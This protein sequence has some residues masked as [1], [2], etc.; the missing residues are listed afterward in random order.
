MEEEATIDDPSVGEGWQKEGRREG[1]LKTGFRSASLCAQFNE[2]RSLQL[3]TTA[4][5]MMGANLE[6]S[7]G[8]KSREKQSS[9]DMATDEIIIEGRRE[10]YSLRAAQH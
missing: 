9:S 7:S 6:S 5:T 1:K 8:E 10:G 2:L 3:F 4:A